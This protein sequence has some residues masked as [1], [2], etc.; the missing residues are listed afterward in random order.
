[1]IDFTQEIEED[2]SS[3]NKSDPGLGIPECGKSL[4]QAKK[5][6]ALASRAI[7]V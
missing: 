5:Q 2:N 6:K 1:M 7:D 4:Q 3:N